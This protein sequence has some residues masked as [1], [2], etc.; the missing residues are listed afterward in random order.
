MSVARQ[1]ADGC[2]RQARVKLQDA[3]RAYQA[4]VGKRAEDE[5]AFAVRDKEQR[6]R[7]ALFEARA[8]ELAPS[9]EA[10]QARIRRGQSELEEMALNEQHKDQLAQRDRAARMHQKTF[11]ALQ[12]ALSASEA[13]EKDARVAREAEAKCV[14]AEAGRRDA[15]RAADA[16]KELLILARGPKPAPARPDGAA[17]AGA[18]KGAT[19]AW[20]VR[21]RKRLRLGR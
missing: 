15:D 10:A 12:A 6:E 21:S 3:E 17:A 8:L 1:H 13:R 16:C 5:A 14:A 7:H 18:Q 4:A 11:L 20:V 9:L 2:L 19:S